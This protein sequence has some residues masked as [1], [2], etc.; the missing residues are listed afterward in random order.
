LKS[1]SENDSI[2]Q[3]K[4]NFGNFGQHLKPLLLLSICT[5]ILASSIPAFSWVATG[6][7]GQNLYE[8]VWD[9]D[10]VGF[11]EGY[12]RNTHRIA[13]GFNHTRFDLTLTAADMFGWQFEP[14]GEEEVNHLVNEADYYP[15][16]GYSFVLLPFGLIM[17][18]F[19]YEPKD[20]KNRLMWFSVWAL[21][22]FYWAIFPH[23]LSN[24]NSNFWPVFNFFKL[25]AS[26]I[27]DPTFSWFWVI[28][29]LGWLYL[30]L[31]NFLHDKKP[32]AAYTWLMMTLVLGIV[33]VQM[34]YWIG[35]Q[36]YSTRYYY[37]ALAAAAL[38]TAIPLGWLAQKFSRKLILAAVL[39]L[40][41]FTLYFYSTPRINVLY[42]FNGVRGD[43][44]AEVEAARVD[45]R[46]I[47]VIVNGPTSPDSERVRWAA[48][49]SLLGVTSP[50]L[51]SDIVV[52]RDTGGMREQLIAAYPDR[53]VIDVDAVFYSA[54]VRQ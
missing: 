11:G 52:V 8:L 9:Y 42:H 14:I 33:V 27:D 48:Y 20:W 45:E 41:I 7:P 51:D 44:I 3:F 35:S 13:K 2:F 38:L 32:Q 40:S 28:T 36:R 4:L 54:Q 15:A 29:A 46:P 47:L 16:R 43:L 50:Y 19:F 6:D 30:P 17:G 10:R 39:G 26:L 24:P 49:G 18:I 34:T 1:L 25:Q 31:I 5:L 21:L 12:G 22:A 23:E 53:Q 37:E